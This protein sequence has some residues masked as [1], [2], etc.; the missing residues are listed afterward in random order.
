MKY[1][2]ELEYII[3]CALTELIELKKKETGPFRENLVESYY[4]IYMELEKENN[5]D[6]ENMKLE[7]HKG[8]KIPRKRVII[9]IE[10]QE[11]RILSWKR[12]VG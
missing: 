9:I 4:Q 3:E 11:P 2:K 1:S 5:N 8:H 10:F 6:W 12:K 7:C